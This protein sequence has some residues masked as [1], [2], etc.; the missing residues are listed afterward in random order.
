M[1]TWRRG[2]TCGMRRHMSAFGGAGSFEVKERTK[3][4]SRRSRSVDPGPR[5]LDAGCT[6]RFG[7]RLKIEEIE[8][9][10]CTVGTSTGNNGGRGRTRS[11]QQGGISDRTVGSRGSNGSTRNRRV[12]GLGPRPTDV[13]L[14]GLGCMRIVRRYLGQ[15]VGRR[16]TKELRMKG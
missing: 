5:M 11:N 12:A 10:P 7:Y 2:V 9:H 1:G 13:Q 16:R 6:G 4:G 8:D 14:L 3:L 15:T